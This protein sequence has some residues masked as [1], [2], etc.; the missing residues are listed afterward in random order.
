MNNLA[1][2]DRLWKKN[3]WIGSVH[4]YLWPFIYVLAFCL[5]LAAYHFWVR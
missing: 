1:W 4:V 2:L 5:M 3:W